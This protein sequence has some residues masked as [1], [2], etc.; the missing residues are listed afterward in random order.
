MAAT[1][2][3]TAASAAFWKVVSSLLLARTLLSRPTN[4]SNLG[5]GKLPVW[6]PASPSRRNVR[7]PYEP[8]LSIRASDDVAIIGSKRSVPMDFMAADA[9][10]S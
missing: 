4:D 7:T 9:R 5:W 8:I 3:V 1:A 2:T 10:K 6:A